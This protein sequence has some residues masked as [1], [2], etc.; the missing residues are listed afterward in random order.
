MTLSTLP[1]KRPVLPGESLPPAP[2]VWPA[3]APQ[4]PPVG[5]SPAGRLSPVCR[6]L[7]VNDYALPSWA[8][9]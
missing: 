7:V 1:K 9:A 6:S 4:L 8:C 5:L 2:P 3:P